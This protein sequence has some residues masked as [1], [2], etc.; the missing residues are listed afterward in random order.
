MARRKAPK[1]KAAPSSEVASS[2]R[3]N[4]LSSVSMIMLM[5][6]MI[7]AT[8]E[9][10]SPKV[11]TSPSGADRPPRKSA[12]KSRTSGREKSVASTAKSSSLSRS[13]SWSSETN[14]INSRNSGKPIV[15]PL[16]DT[17]SSK[18]ALARRCSSM[19]EVDLGKSLAS[20]LATLLGPTLPVSSGSAPRKLLRCA[21]TSSSEKPLL[22]ASASARS[23]RLC[24]SMA[25]ASHRPTRAGDCG[26]CA[27][28]S[29]GGG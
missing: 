18:R 27:A 10:K 28:P 16:P 19:S 6:G 21:R 13:R 5:T 11:I 15:P 14:R 2:S 12:R 1:P 7:R 29:R 24:L 20:S 4:C 3:S 25:S 17:A 26:G 8:M 23:R 22:L 9:T